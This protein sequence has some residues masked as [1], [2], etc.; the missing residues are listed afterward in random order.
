MIQFNSTQLKLDLFISG[1][2][3]LDRFIQLIPVLS[4][5]LSLLQF[6]SFN[7]VHFNCVLLST[8]CMSG[9][10]LGSGGHGAD[11]M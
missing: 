1:S 9:I 8:Y 10:A 11:K 3:Q 5:Q 4:N 7:S 6:I 2:F